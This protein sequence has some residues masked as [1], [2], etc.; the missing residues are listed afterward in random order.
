MLIT[1]VPHQWL[2]MREAA[3]VSGRAPPPPLVNST[4]PWEE[5]EGRPLSR[6]DS[7]LA[8][9][10]SPHRSQSVFRVSLSAIYRALRRELRG[11]GI[12]S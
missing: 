5:P 6:K 4:D 2:V 3:Q 8:I 1:N 11:V 9:P 7:T 10:A 12:L